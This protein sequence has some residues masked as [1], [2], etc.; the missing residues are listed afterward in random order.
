MRALEVRRG[1]DSTRSFPV[2]AGSSEVYGGTCELLTFHSDWPGSPVRLSSPNQ[3]GKFRLSW[4][5][6]QIRAELGW[7]CRWLGHSHRMSAQA[8]S[9]LG[10]RVAA[11]A[12]LD[13][14]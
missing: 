9:A 4:I 12:A 1:K 2:H 3:R 14:L 13:W 6:R 11:Y 8:D 10:P 5:A 7:N